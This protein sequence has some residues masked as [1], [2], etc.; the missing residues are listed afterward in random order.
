MRI[1]NPVIS[2]LMGDNT[3]QEN[4][5]IPASYIYEGYS[6]LEI[7]TGYSIEISTSGKLWIKPK[8]E[9]VVSLVY[10]TSIGTLSNLGSLTSTIAINFNTSDIFFGILTGATTFTFSNPR[11]GNFI[12]RVQHDSSSRIITF[13]TCY[14]IG[15]VGLT[16]ATYTAA[17]GITR[18]T[19]FSIFCDGNDY[20]IGE[21]YFGT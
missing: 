7:T 2:A 1:D 15:V 17:A 5:V 4:V 16:A 12:I 3:V 8:P 14:Y 6:P 9:D 21:S 20:W 10:T 13:P 11:V 18:Y 19:I